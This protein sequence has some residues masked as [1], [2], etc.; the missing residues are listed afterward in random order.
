[1][2][3]NEYWRIVGYRSAKRIFEDY[4]LLGSLSEK[5]MTSVLRVL[6]ARAGLTFEEILDSC[7]RRNAKRYKPLLE[8]RGERRGKFILTCG[9]NPYFVASVVKK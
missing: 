7:S 4:V 9:E 6:A 2:R 5:E 8:V 1:M 3:T